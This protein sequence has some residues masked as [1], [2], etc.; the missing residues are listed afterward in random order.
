MKLAKAI[1]LIIACHSA[2]AYAQLISPQE[3]WELAELAVNWQQAGLPFDEAR[4]IAEIE[5]NQEPEKFDA[6]YRILKQV[7]EVN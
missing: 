7:Y 4:F 2:F 3:S 5:F 6:V 1:V